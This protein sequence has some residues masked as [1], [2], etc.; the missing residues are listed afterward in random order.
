MASPRSPPPWH[1]VGDFLVVDYW[2]DPDAAKAVLPEGLDLSPTRPLRRRVR[3]LAV[4]LRGVGR[5]S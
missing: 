1:Y 4:L 3:G 5:S 2:A